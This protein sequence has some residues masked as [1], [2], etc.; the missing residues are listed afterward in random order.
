[1]LSRAFHA[2][3]YNTVALI[4]G[5]TV[6]VVHLAYHAILNDS[7]P[8]DYVWALRTAYTLLHGI[9]SYGFAP[10]PPIRSLSA[11]GCPL[12]VPFDLDYRLC[13]NVCRRLHLHRRIGRGT[14][15]GR[16]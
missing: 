9:N 15:P 12:W 3:R 7:Y 13:S 8:G 5:L 1:M 16:C 11:S 2:K 10:D 14:K 6:G 4:I